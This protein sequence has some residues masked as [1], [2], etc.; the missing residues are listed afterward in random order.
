MKAAWE[1]LSEGDRAAYVRKADE[2]VVR[3]KRELREHE[4]RHL[5]L[6]SLTRTVAGK[7]AAGEGSYGTP[8]RS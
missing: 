3:F 6:F 2:D 4:A 5:E 1:H 7:I 8:G